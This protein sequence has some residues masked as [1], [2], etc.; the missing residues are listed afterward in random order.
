VKEKMRRDAKGSTPT[1]CCRHSLSLV[2][3][4]WLRRVHVVGVGVGVG[5]LHMALYGSTA[6]WRRSTRGG[7]GMWGEI[8]SGQVR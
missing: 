4:D 5:V 8:R 1:G 6:L 2:R 3:L 7:W